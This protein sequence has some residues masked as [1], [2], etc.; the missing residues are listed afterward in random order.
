[1]SLNYTSIPKEIWWDIFFYIFDSIDYAH[2]KDNKNIRWKCPNCPSKKIYTSPINNCYVCQRMTTDIDTEFERNKCF[3]NIAGVSTYWQNITANN[4]TF[5][6]KYFTK[7]FDAYSNSMVTDNLN[8]NVIRDAHLNEKKRYSKLT[9]VLDKDTH[10]MKYLEIQQERFCDKLSKCEFNPNFNVKDNTQE[11][12]QIDLKYEADKLK[13]IRDK[14]ELIPNTKE[15]FP[16]PIQVN[17]IKKNKFSK[18]MKKLLV[19][20]KEELFNDCNETVHFEGISGNQSSNW[21]S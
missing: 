3:R 5:L 12:E 9:D 14:E 4:K 8:H 19:E 15:L 17:T 10:L 18:Q 16:Q 11:L 6:M 1:M 20:R 21:I 13:I 7:Y 2:C